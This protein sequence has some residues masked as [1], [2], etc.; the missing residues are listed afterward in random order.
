MRKFKKIFVS[1]IIFVFCLGVISPAI[2]DIPQFDT[3]ILNPKL[4]DGISILESDLKIKGN[5]NGTIFTFAET[6]MLYFTVRFDNGYSFSETYSSFFKNASSNAHVI[7][8]SDGTMVFSYN[9]IQSESVPFSNLNDI[10]IN[11]T[12]ANLPK[13]EITIDGSFSNIN[14]TDWVVAQFKLTLGTKQ[15][16][17]GAYE[18]NGS[19]KG[20]GNTSWG[21]PKKPYSIKLSSKT[22]L[23]DIPATKKYAIVANYQDPTL[24]RNFLTYKAGNDLDGIG[25]TVKCEF[26]DVYLNGSYNGVYILVER[27]DIEKTKVNINEANADNISGGYLIEKDAGDKVDYEKDYWFDAPF[28]SNPN[29][30]LF[31]LKAP[32]PET[33]DGEVDHTL[34]NAML[35]YLEGY[36]ADVQEA[37]MSRDSEHCYNYVD[38]DSWVDFLIMQ[39]ITKNV[40]G[41]LKTS[42]YMYK[43]RED[44]HLYFTSL[45]DFDLAYGIASW[46]NACENNDWYDCPE[47]T[48]T[49]DFM[50]LNS[51][52]P[53]FL[54][55][56][57]N[58]QDF[59]Q[60]VKEKYSEYRYTL[61]EDLYNNID[62]QAAYI[63]TA[64]VANFNLWNN[65]NDFDSS[66]GTLKTWLDGR[67]N[68]LDSHWLNENSDTHTLTIETEGGEAIVESI[69]GVTATS[70]T[71]ANG[72]KISL[73]INAVGN[74]VI[75]GLTI[76][77]LDISDCYSEG[78]F[79]SPIITEDT[80]LSL[81]F[82]EIG[83]ANLDGFVNTGD[84][85]AILSYLVGSADFSSVNLLT[86]DM[87]HDGAV[88]TGDAAAIL[89]YSIN[90]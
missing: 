42:C 87:N 35:S 15:F 12:A 90:T 74:K 67:L 81:R 32:E 48:G 53:W 36:M 41:N 11:A 69:D 9:A 73:N 56:Y 75:I 39:E 23:L 88:N 71:V 24:M 14:K 51:S 29:D 16:T 77:D 20:R 44:S 63:Q 72:G 19:I 26:V 25:Y 27:I 89:S 40:D 30:D 47:G 46:S 45:W 79:Y 8:N 33:A 3:Y 59:N 5:L 1:L 17:S 80:I 49:S 52:C 58:Y 38:M 6:K 43:D 22:S 68:W 13:L 28:Q 84:A 83:D 37:I 66:I 61:L 2:A 7:E 78:I 60:K 57:N 64:A 62:T 55:M 65:E 4:S 86:S 21:D 10:H 82:S 70:F 54:N 85:S 34:I 31:T 76:G 50:V 18:G